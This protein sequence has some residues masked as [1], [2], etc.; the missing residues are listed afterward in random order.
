MADSLSELSQSDLIIEAIVEK[1]EVKQSLFKDLENFVRPDAVLAS[2][3]SSL[4]IAEIFKECKRPEQGIGM[5]YFSPV[6]KMPLLELIYTDKTSTET[7]RK[8]YDVGL[9]QG[10]TVIAVK[11]GPGFYT[12]RILAP[13]MN[14]ALLIYEEG[15]DPEK[16]DRIMKKAGFP[17]GP[18]ALLDEVGLDVAAHVGTTLKEM[19]EQ[20]GGKTSTLAQRL[21]EEGILGRK[22]GAGF[23]TYSKK[24]KVPNSEL[25]RFRNG[26]GQPL[27]KID[28]TDADIRDRL[29]LM[30]INE[31]VYTLEEGIL[32][33]AEDGD[34][35]AIMGLGYP[36]FL[37]GPFLTI[38]R[39]GASAIVNRMQELQNKFGD[40]FRPA[41]LLLT[42]AEEKRCFTEFGKLYL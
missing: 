24:K 29:L 19:F 41:P 33:S 32:G 28:L 40:R 42:H 22:S 39:M 7:L 9:R 5:H 10:K 1:L 14:E 17:V 31:A 38:D 4:P 34:L 23:Y 12:T 37:G 18:Y 13:F 6:Q 30:M 16:I 11:D 8:A 36:P 35:G 2:N 20:R 26:A 25:E 3:T 21:F 15:G 27:S